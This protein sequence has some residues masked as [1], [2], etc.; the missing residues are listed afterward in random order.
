MIATA[1]NAVKINA[2][3]SGPPVL[4]VLSLAALTTN[5]VPFNTELTFSTAILPTSLNTCGATNTNATVA[6]ITTTT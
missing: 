5:A 1:N 4:T 2:I 3:I 6:I